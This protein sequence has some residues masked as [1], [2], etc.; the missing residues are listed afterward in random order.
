[1]RLNVFQFY[2]CDYY[3]CQDNRRGNHLWWIALCI[4]LLYCDYYCQYR[5]SRYFCAPRASRLFFPWHIFSTILSRFPF[6][7][8]FME[9]GTNS[10]RESQIDDKSTILFKSIGKGKDCMLLHN[11]ANF[12]HL[13]SLRGNNFTIRLLP[14]ITRRCSYV[15]NYCIAIQKLSG[16]IF[17]PERKNVR[18]LKCR[19]RD[20]IVFWKMYFYNKHEAHD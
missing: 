20:I 14:V 1:M 12:I 6:F 7:F 10:T 2:F 13:N 16:I 4:I 8:S 17:T 9:Q 18:Y 3:T 11:Y 5:W 19:A 15:R